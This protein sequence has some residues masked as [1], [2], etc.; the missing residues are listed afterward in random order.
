MNTKV[1]WKIFLLVKDDCL[2]VESHCHQISSD[3][4]CRDRFSR[5]VNH[6]ERSN[7]AE[8]P[9]GC[10]WIVYNWRHRS[11]G[12]AGRNWSKQSK[13]ER[14]TET[15]NQTWNVWIDLEPCFANRF[16]R[17]TQS[18]PR[19]SCSRS[20]LHHYAT[21]SHQSID[22]RVNE[23][24]TESNLQWSDRFVRRLRLKTRIDPS[25]VVL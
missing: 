12:S 5:C 15:M 9:I 2:V 25:L 23:S 21:K 8:C 3:S 7:Y 18:I 24:E 4:H 19:C 22:D 6:G 16:D 14:C 11:F 10:R 20:Y 17:E 1:R 13:I